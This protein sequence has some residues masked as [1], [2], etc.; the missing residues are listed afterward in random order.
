MINRLDGWLFS[1]TG[2][3]VVLFAV[4]H[5][6]D[7]GV[8]RDRRDGAGRRCKI[9]ELARQVVVDGDET[10]HHVVGGESG[11]LERVQ[12][13]IA[14]G[15]ELFDLGPRE[16]ATASQ[17]REHLFA[18]FAGL[19]DHFATLLFGKFDFGFG[20]CGCIV[21]TAHRLEFGL[22]AQPGGVSRG[23]FDQAGGVFLGPLAD[24]GARLAGSPEDTGGLFAEQGGHDLFV[25]HSGGGHPP[26]LHRLQFA[27]EE[28]LALLQT[29]ELGRDHAQEVAHLGLVIAT[30]CDGE[31]RSADGC[32]RRRVG[33]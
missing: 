11:T 30:A 29:G 20:I 16:F 2:I 5:L 28:P 26:C 17:F 31:R 12:Q 4:E 23:F 8:E 22:F 3:E 21:A 14:I 7:G 18:V 13:A 6:N 27:F 24:L 19:V 33:A 9:H 25:E 1:P 10:G 32:G 15:H